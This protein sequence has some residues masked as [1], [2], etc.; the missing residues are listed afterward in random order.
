MNGDI[1]LVLIVVGIIGGSHIIATSAALLLLMKLSLLSRFLPFIEHRG[2][3]IGLIFLTLS[4]L[5]PFVRKRL[6]LKQMK[7]VFTSVPGI[8][9][10]CSGMLATKLNGDGVKMLLQDPQLI[11]GLV[12]G[13]IFGIIFLKGSA[14][15]PLMGAGI[16]VLLMKIFSVF[17]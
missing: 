11:V 3:E 8:V 12:I 1:V 7:P 2:V 14:A 10:L 15:G 9:A 6:T 16:T 5:A 17:T 4:V 13:S